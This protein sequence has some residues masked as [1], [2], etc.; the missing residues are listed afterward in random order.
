MKRTKRVTETI[1]EL[2]ALMA[3]AAAQRAVKRIE[4]GDPC[5]ADRWA[6]HAIKW[7]DKS[8]AHAMRW[9]YDRPRLNT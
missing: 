7:M 5:D 6:T 3:K 2:Y 4:I 1:N 9:V 8:S